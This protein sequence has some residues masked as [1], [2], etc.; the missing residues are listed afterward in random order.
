MRECEEKGEDF[1]C[2][3]PDPVGRLIKLDTKIELAKEG[4]TSD[5]L[6]MIADDYAGMLES[7]WGYFESKERLTE[8]L[9][10]IT[11]EEA[12]DILERGRE[13]GKYTD[14]N[15]NSLKRMIR[16]HFNR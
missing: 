3:D 9:D 13:E 2:S 12:E 1:I 4:I 16:Q 14:D 7:G 8:V 15:Y 10:K 11:F 6:G 5:E